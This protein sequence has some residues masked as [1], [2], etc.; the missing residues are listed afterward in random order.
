ME[1]LGQLGVKWS[2]CRDCG[3]EEGHV[4]TETVIEPPEDD[5]IGDPDPL[6]GI[7]EI[8]PPEGSMEERGF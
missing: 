7:I 4:P 5:P 8:D 6:D 3:S 2:H 1:Y